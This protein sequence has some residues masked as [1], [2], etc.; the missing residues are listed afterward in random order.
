M[1]RPSQ[2][3]QRRGPVTISVWFPALL[4][5]LAI[6]AACTQAE[7]DATVVTN[8]PVE[9]G[10]AVL[11]TADLPVQR[12][13]RDFVVLATD[14]P[15]PPFSD[16]DQFGNVIGYN[17]SVM[18]NIAATAALDYEFV[19]TPSQGVLGSIAAGSAR[20]FDA[21]MSALI[22][23]D[24][25]EAGIAYTDP[26]LE[27]GQ[28]VLV[29][30]DEQRIQSVADIQSGMAIG[31]IDGSDSY[32]AALASGIPDNDL[33]TEFE[34]PSQLIQ[35]LID[36][37]VDA[38]IVD[39]HVGSYFASTFPE[40]LRVAGGEGQA[41]WLSSKQY[42]MAV[43]ADN[44]EL[45]LRLNEAIAGL[46]EDGTLDRLALT[47]LVAEQDAAASVDPGE[48][49]VGTPGSELV[50]GVVG[51]FDNMD[52]ASLDTSFIAWELMNNTMSGLYRFTPDNVLEPLLASA[53]PE[54]S[55]DKLEYTIRLR[56]GLA[57]PDGRLFT[58]EDVRWS[59][60]RAS[61]LGNFVVN[62]YLKDANEDNFADDD[63]VQ[64]LDPL[65]VKIVLKAPTAYFPSILATPPF[66]PISADCY[67]EAAD[68]GSRCGGLGPYTIAG[69]EPNDRMRLT[70]NPGWPGRPAPAFENI[71]VRFYD[72][73]EGMQ[74][75]LTEFESVDLAW[76]GLPYTDFVA[77][78]ALDRDED[79]EADLRPWTGPSTFKSYLMFEQS[80]EPWD[81]EKVRQAV[82]YALD[83]AALADL[84]GGERLALRSPVP[85]DIPG[86]IET[87]P[88]RD[89]D[90]ARTLLL[91]EGYSATSPIE[92]TLW[93]VNDGRYSAV[94][95]QYAAAIK[96]QLE[97][98]GVFFV[99]T[100]GVTWDQFRLDIAQCNY[101]TFLL[102]WPSPG[103]AVDYLDASSW[104]DF[105]VFSTT[106]VFCSNYESEE[107][108]AL[109]DAARAELDET[110]RL[111]LLAEIQ[112]LWAEELPTL[113]LTQQPRRAISLPEVDGVRV[114]SLGIMHY[115]LL[116]KGE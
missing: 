3:T 89:L 35:A 2:P 73:A 75:S 100:S 12:G 8:T 27:V 85:N 47:W 60:L 71:M 102:G 7:P 91:E 58:A 37:A 14:A 99:T 55:E 29:L 103:S 90:R 59:I 84:F 56:D 79:G 115:E 24:Q 92:M 74:R 5:L 4:V 78:S 16:F 61:R 52:P 67:V 31:V 10:T 66:F 19:V 109:V 23:P 15:F 95:E 33:F 108:V 86:A 88:E 97:E 50:I 76:T 1:I 49:R 82:S 93:F 105:F 28:V 6:L 48:S 116:T 64:V 22:I 32:E 54:I 51:Q 62:T 41:A 111:A 72:T 39:S 9:A 68:P 113:D 107:M 65:T 70:A 20:D 40:Q 114:D 98:T 94:E 26:Y 18:E 80:T 96:A 81:K 110:A 11:P 53:L 36:E 101:P 112:T 25:P 21:V 106:R 57:F 42:G 77:L 46:R 13:G 44:A 43:A 104:T 17:A 87:L 83:H 30:V 69:W 63:S 34:Q 45:R 38:V